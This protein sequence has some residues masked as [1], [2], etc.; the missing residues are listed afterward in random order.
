MVHWSMTAHQRHSVT[1]WFTGQILRGICQEDDLVGDTQ[2][3]SRTEKDEV[4]LLVCQEDEPVGDTQAPSRTE[5]DD[6]F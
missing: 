4:F 5:R 1:V 3:P 2:A 6:V